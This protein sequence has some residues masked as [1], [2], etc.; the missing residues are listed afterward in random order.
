MD[1]RSFD[2][3]TRGL[4]H[5]ASRRLAVT[6]LVSGLLG[7]GIF[8][9]TDAQTEAE[10]CQVRAC[11]KKILRQ[12]CLDRNGNPE[13]RQCCPGLKCS[14]RRGQCVFKNDHGTAGDFCRNTDD[15]DFGYFCKKNQCIPDDCR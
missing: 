11:R 7:L 12:N 10:G 6:G 15:C 14:N 13:N 4:T 9:G 2:A 1:G 5:Q 8:Q 3:L